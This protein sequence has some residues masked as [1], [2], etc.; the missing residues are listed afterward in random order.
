MAKDRGATGNG[1]NE[2]GLRIF[3]FPLDIRPGFIVLL[4][5][6]AIVYSGQGEGEFGIWLAVC[7][8]GF[9]LA[10]ELGHAFA[11]RATGAKAS[12]ALDFLAGY[13]SF[14]PTRPLK[15]WERAGISVAGPAVQIL[16]GA[17][18]LV[19][20][21]ANPL[22]VD[23]VR[24][25]T[26]E[27][28]VWWAGPVIGLINLAPILPLDGGHIVMSGLDLVLPGRSRNVMLYFSV[29]ATAGAL[30]FFSVSNYRISP[31]FFIFPLITQIQMLQHRHTQTALDRHGSWQLWAASAERDAW[32]TAKV[33]SFPPGITVSPWF[34]AAELARRGNLDDA[35]NLLV[36]D[37]ALRNSPNWLPPDAADERELEALVGLLPR[38]LPTGNVYSEYVLASVLVRLGEFD[39]AGRYA[40]E[41]Y[42]RSPGTMPAVIVAQC[43][44]ALADAEL[45]IKWLRAGY[46]VGT[47]L[48]GLA[49]AIEHRSEF[50][51]IRNRPEVVRL[52]HELAAAD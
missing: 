3:G 41:S 2:S 25:L 15:R 17:A 9:T 28:A 1:S 10:H 19:A 48:P 29:V 38:P 44:A 16:L 46:D 13:A 26:I 47:N 21:G 37:F 6:F 45:A 11:A 31:I 27:T 7:V 33:G 40:A 23:D 8:A 51:D 49:D 12:I 50:T 30:V 24:G 52:R 4:A 36:A 18:V 42:S 14:E 5:L 22:D 39:D 35:R 32:T 34:R 43:A 20:M